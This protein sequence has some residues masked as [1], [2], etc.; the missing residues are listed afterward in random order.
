MRNI[1]IKT[2]GLKEIF[3]LFIIGSLLTISGMLLETNLNYLLF[4]FGVFSLVLCFYS[5]ILYVIIKYYQKKIIKEW[6]MN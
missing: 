4:V 1:N 5:I 2:M 6:L 3:I